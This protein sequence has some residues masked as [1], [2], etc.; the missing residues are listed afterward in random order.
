MP[1]SGWQQVNQVTKPKTKMSKQ[2]PHPTS[3]NEKDINTNEEVTNSFSNDEISAVS[4]IVNLKQSCNHQF[5]P[6]NEEDRIHILSLKSAAAQVVNIFETLKSENDNRKRENDSIKA[7][8]DSF[9]K[10][11]QN[12][13]QRLNALENQASN[14][15]A[16]IRSKTTKIVKSLAENVQPNEENTTSSG[17]FDIL[18]EKLADEEDNMSVEEE[19]SSSLDSEEKI[20]K[21]E[22]SWITVDYNKKKTKKKR[23]KPTSPSSTSEDEISDPE[24]RSRRKIFKK[25]NNQA[26][27]ITKENGQI[28]NSGSNI[29]KSS[30]SNNPVNTTN[31]KNNNTESDNTKTKT[32]PPPPIKII[33]IKSFENLQKILKVASEKEEYMIRFLG[34][35]MWKINPQTETAFKN[36]RE[37]L[38]KNNIQWYTHADKNNRNIKVMCRGLPTSLNPDEIVQDLKEKNFKIISAVC[39]QKRIE[40]KNKNKI[41]E[42]TENKDNPS[43]PKNTDNNPPQKIIKKYEYIKIPLYQLDFDHNESAEKIYNIKAILHTIVK[44][45]P[46]KI[47]PKIIPQ[48]KRCCGYF[49]TANFCQKSP[50]CVKCAGKHYSHECEHKGMIANPKCAICGNIG[51]PASYRGCP[52]AKELQN[53]R[54]KQLKMK[55]QNSTSAHTTKTVIKNSQP[56]KLEKT[57]AQATQGNA[58]P[59]EKLI[60]TLLKT[61]ESLNEQIISLNNKISKMETSGRR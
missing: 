61:I 29:D 2:Q 16:K 25:I 24:Y 42:N 20:V 33:G 37:N 18:A 51:H 10:T 59:S 4:A 34:D 35:D 31:P 21:Q 54:K 44:I 40:I 1:H 52:V 56:K 5:I 6:S 23:T 15:P 27:K 14:S 11:I 46:I 9:K 57:F 8:N 60:E 50:R 7:E 41:T 43:E 53:T 22:T 45:E 28:N 39:M 19:N 30:N 48:C 38:N 32:L 58:N 12:L 26:S 49:H 13:S 36:I 17:K 55:K 47:N 3:A